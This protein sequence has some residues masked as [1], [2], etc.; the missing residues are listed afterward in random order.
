QNARAQRSVVEATSDEG[1]GQ[2]SSGQHTDHTQGHREQTLNA[3][4]GRR[5][6]AIRPLEERRNPER[7]SE[8]RQREEREP[9]RVRE[10][11]AA[12][13]ID[14]PTR[15]A[16]RSGAVRVSRSTGGFANRE[17]QQHDDEA[18]QSCD[19]KRRLPRPDD[20]D[21][22]NPPRLLDARELSDP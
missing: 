12:M 8:V 10:E 18:W 5:V 1:V 4:R 7:E 22:W 21:D 13:S 16:E 17:N 3:R 11:R 15:R 14:E 19:E 20:T 6:P 9:E 2:P